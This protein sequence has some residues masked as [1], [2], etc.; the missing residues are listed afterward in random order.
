MVAIFEGLEKFAGEYLFTTTGGSKPISLGSKIKNRLDA[1]LQFEEG[2]INHDLRRTVATH[3][4]DDLGV[5]ETVTDAIL[6]H[7]K[8]GSEGIYNRAEYVE[9][10]RAALELWSD[11]VDPPPM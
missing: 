8:K 11:Y 5:K 4:T 2:W 7:R 10:R 6:A 1:E 9:Q 3:L